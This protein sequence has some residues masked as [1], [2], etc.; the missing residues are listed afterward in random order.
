MLTELGSVC[1]HHRN[2]G[3]LGTYCAPGTLLG[4]LASPCCPVFIENKTE[5][6]RGKL[7]YLKSHSLEFRSKADCQALVPGADHRLVF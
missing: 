6:Q 7:F 4:L 5:S 2:H 1:E 3:A